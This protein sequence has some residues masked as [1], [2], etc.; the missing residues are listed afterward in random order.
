MVDFQCFLTAPGQVCIHLGI[1][2]PNGIQICADTCICINLEQIPHAPS[3]YNVFV[4]HRI[5][6]RPGLFISAVVGETEL[7]DV[8][9]VIFDLSFAFLHDRDATVV[10]GSHEFIYG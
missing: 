7:I 2:I 9:F 10:V 6:Y 8:P 3:A 1:Y 4:L 5:L